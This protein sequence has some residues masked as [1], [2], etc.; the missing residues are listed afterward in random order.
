MVFVLLGVDAWHLRALAQFQESEMSPELFQDFMNGYMKPEVSP[1]LPFE[2][3]VVVMTAAPNQDDFRL[4]T[5][6]SQF[7]IPFFMK[8]LFRISGGIKF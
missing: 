3:S 6:G 8:F 4:N 5:M 1:P 2:H 7:S